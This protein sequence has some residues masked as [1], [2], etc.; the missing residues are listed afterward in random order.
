M[1]GTY[2]AN[3]LLAMGSTA[4]TVDRASF[5]VLFDPAGYGFQALVPGWED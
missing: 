3:G 4:K 2:Q 1:S 5:Y